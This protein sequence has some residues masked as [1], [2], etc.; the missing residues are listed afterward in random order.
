MSYDE[1]EI[2]L[3]FNEC[4]KAFLLEDAR[5]ELERLGDT[6]CEEKEKKSGIFYKVK[7][8]IEKIKNWIQSH[9]KK[10]EKVKVTKEEKKYII[11]LKSC[12]KRIKSNVKH[13]KAWIIL[14]VLVAGGVGIKVHGN[15]KYKKN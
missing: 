2:E 3:A 7:E 12:L 1:L 9:L 10:N 13:P 14:G 11:K 5:C 6:F 8:L 4:E 15:I